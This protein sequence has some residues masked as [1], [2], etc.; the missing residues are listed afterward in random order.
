MRKLLK[1]EG[2]QGEVFSLSMLIRTMKESKAF[3]ISMGLNGPHIS[4]DLWA[5]R[6]SRWTSG[7][8]LQSRWAINA[9]GIWFISKSSNFSATPH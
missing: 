8:I 5:G 3:K 4:V 9:A 7:P 6:A 2:Q 1:V